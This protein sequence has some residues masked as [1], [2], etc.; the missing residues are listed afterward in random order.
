[1]SFS[2]V[3]AHQR[4]PSWTKMPWGRAPGVG[5]ERFV[6][7]VRVSMRKRRRAGGTATHMLS[8]FTHWRP[9]APELRSL[10]SM[11]PLPGVSYRPTVRPW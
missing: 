1:M 10:P 7:M 5:M 3:S 11:T 8:S 2:V 6:S 4:A 9:W